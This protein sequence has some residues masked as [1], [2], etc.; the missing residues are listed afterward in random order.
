MTLPARP[1]LGVSHHRHKCGVQPD[2]ALCGYVT[3]P[4]KQYTLIT[5]ADAGYYQDCTVCEDLL[6]GARESNLHCGRCREKI[7]P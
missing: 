1:V 3:E 7:S 2:A 5:P 6:A 4:G